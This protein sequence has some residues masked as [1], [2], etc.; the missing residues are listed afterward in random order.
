MSDQDVH[1][2][3]EPHTKQFYVDLGERVLWT[4]VQ[5]GLSVVTVDQFDLNPIY[6]PI[7]AAGLAVLKGYVA[8]YIGNPNSASTTESV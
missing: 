8:S 1:Y 5:A 4:A 3:D 7:I 2:E 6:L